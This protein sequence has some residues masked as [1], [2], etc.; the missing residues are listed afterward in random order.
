[1]EVL[2]QLTKPRIGRGERAPL[3]G[4]P[5]SE[6]GDLPSE[7]I[8]AV[9]LRVCAH[10]RARACKGAAFPHTLLSSSYSLVGR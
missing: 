2:V 3:S 7:I 10:A 9:L 8:G 1:V 5:S 4:R 6:R